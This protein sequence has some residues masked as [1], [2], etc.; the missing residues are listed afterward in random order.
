MKDLFTTD[1]C[2][3]LGPDG[4]CSRVDLGV[5]LW[6]S[7]TCFWSLRVVI[8]I[9]HADLGW[10]RDGTTCLH[11]DLHVR[12]RS[13]AAKIVRPRSFST[14]LALKFLERLSRYKYKCVPPDFYA[15]IMVR[16][17]RGDTDG[18]WSRSCGTQGRAWVVRS[19]VDH[20]LRLLEHDTPPTYL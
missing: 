13:V 19:A 2:I 8:A 10:T 16:S 15:V 1:T 7:L 4:V 5:W 17:R 20:L 12:L 9:L 18:H 11:A 3:G 14:P 6:I